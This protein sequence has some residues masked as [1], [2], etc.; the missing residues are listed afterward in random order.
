[1]DTATAAVI[2]AAI[3]GV[4]TVV[5]W[6]VSHLLSERRENRTRRL[7][8]KLARLER[9]IEE[10]YGPLFSLIEQVFNV[11][12]VRRNLLSAGEGGAKLSAEEQRQVRNFV[13]QNYFL[14]LHLQ[15]RKLL[16]SKIHLVEGTRIPESFYKYLEHATQETLQHK[17]WEQAK[18]G[19]P[20]VKGIPW[21]KDFH[22]DVRNSLDRAMAEYDRCIRDLEPGRVFA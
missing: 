1:M 11:W 8:A 22:E 12:T 3:T 7:Q 2:G 18:I 15:I 6:N 19:T 20:H 14:P 10:F 13:W 16:R 17:L 21:P 5:G 4:V 9:Q